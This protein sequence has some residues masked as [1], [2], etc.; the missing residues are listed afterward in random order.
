M[1]FRI[2]YGIVSIAD[3]LQTNKYEINNSSIDLVKRARYN[4]I[5]KEGGI[6][7]HIIWKRKT[8]QEIFSEA[9]HNEEFVRSDE[10]DWG[11][12]QGEEIW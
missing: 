11:A 6:V 8:L 4:G 2:D 1:R 3:A 9:E 7:M 12:P 5:T 10:I